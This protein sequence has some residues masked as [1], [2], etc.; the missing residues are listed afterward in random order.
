MTE[1]LCSLRMLAICQFEQCDIL[2]FD[3]F[4]L[5]SGHFMWFNPIVNVETLDW[6]LSSVFPG[7]KICLENFFLKNFVI[8]T[9]F[10][11]CFS[12][13]WV[14]KDSGCRFALL[15]RL[16]LLSHWG[17]LQICVTS[18]AI[19]ILSSI[20]CVCASGGW[21]YEPPFFFLW[22]LSLLCPM[23]IFTYN[24]YGLDLFSY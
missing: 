21:A 1:V 18:T 19:N 8:F 17:L 20:S 9:L 23:F 14:I 12:W 5:I 22:V 10:A 15:L 3:H 6:S 13:K 24:A 11:V 16:C 7:F 2:I 4:W